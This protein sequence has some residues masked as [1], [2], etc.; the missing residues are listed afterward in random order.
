MYMERS[1]K[2]EIYFLLNLNTE[3]AFQYNRLPYLAFLIGDNRKK[4]SVFVET[5]DHYGFSKRMVGYKRP[6][7]LSC[8]G[9]LFKK[10]ENK[11]DIFLK[12]FVILYTDDAVLMAESASELQTF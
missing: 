1:C 6:V 7:I 9:K 8:F 3:H 5:D 11:I 10:L 4:S 2:V 12:L